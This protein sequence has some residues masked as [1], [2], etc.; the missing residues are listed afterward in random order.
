MVC[1]GHA[2]EAFAELK[3]E[4]RGQSIQDLLSRL[5]ELLEKQT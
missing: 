2:M 1:F 3:Q 4:I 5:R